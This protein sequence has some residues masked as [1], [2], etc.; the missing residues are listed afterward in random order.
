MLLLRCCLAALAGLMIVSCGETEPTAPTPQKTTV[1]LY[2]GMEPSKSAR[3]SIAGVPLDSAV[4]TGARSLIRQI[5]ASSEPVDVVVDAG[6]GS[7]PYASARVVFPAEVPSSAVVFPATSAFEPMRF[8]DS[9]VVVRDSGSPA[10]GKARI[11][12]I[13]AS[14][15]GTWTLGELSVYVDQT[16]AFSIAD[17]PLR[18]VS[19]WVSVDPGER[20]IKVVR[21]WQ[22]PYDAATRGVTFVQGA[23]YTLFLTGTLNTGDAWVFTARLYSDN[24]QSAA[25]D[26]LIPPDVGSF[27]VVNAVTGIRSIDVKID[28]KIIPS[29][30]QIPFPNATGYLELDLGTH[31]LEILTNGTPL[32][33][34]VRT[35][36]TLRSRKTMFVSG[37]LVPPNIVGLELSE[38]E[39]APNA[40]L[41]YIRFGNLCPDAPMIDIALK[42]DT[43]ETIPEGFRSLEFR[44]FSTIPGSQDQFLALAPGTYTI[45]A[46]RA[47]TRSIVLPPSDVR[48]DAGQVRTLWTGG[49]L[50][51]ISLHSVTHAK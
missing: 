12:V 25:V 31:A 13:N 15:A 21:Q 27:Q 46:Y 47:G 3:L 34:N 45:I 8:A 14:D 38:P 40:A 4:P 19:K 26:L 23:S 6:E 44:E 42:Q 29:M 28:G 17:L 30:S 1:R 33:D 5:D 50:S 39:R 10:P 37:T 2:N 7:Q 18:K 32:V 35:I 36:A 24:D 22:I 51:K 11:R 43:T 49:L 9:V 48:V 16:Q 41:A 20:Q